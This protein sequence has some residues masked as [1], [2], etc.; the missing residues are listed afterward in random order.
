MAF[1]ESQL[2]KFI[3]IFRLQI[4]RLPKPS[5]PVHGDVEWLRD[6]PRFTSTQVTLFGRPFRI[7]DS[8][9][10]Y[11]S[12]TEIFIRD[13]YKFNARSPEPYII[14]CGA[15]CGASIIYF[16]RLY[17]KAR[18]V[19]FEPDPY[20]F[21]ILESNIMAFGLQDVKLFN[22]ALWHSETSL[23][24]VPTKADTGR[25]VSEPTQSSIN[26]STVPLSSY[27]D[28]PVDILKVDVEGSEVD[29]LT[30]TPNLDRA[31]YLF[32]EYH[33][34]KARPQRLHELLQVLTENGF[35]YQIHTQF[36]SR[37]PFVRIEC[38]S[39]VDLQLNIF[40]YRNTSF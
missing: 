30:R 13:I 18:V 25:V 27:L 4:T 7:V 38:Q 24:F 33:S 40:A 15:N 36:S 21:G 28:Q 3:R 9:S 26:V 8:L 19:A 22:C 20:I 35:R 31:L 17:P 39:G 10:F 29:I 12:Y 5:L 14:D 6:F 1:I 2:R 34:F 23:P 32:V 16:K 11:Y 37:T